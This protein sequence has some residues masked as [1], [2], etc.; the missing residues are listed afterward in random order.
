MNAH[1]N[2]TPEIDFEHY[3][4]LAADLRRE[5]RHLSLLR[6]WRAL[7]RRTPPSGMRKPHSAAATPY[8]AGS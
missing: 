7:T 4:R 1:F 2:P 5:T 8:P 6:L 3:R